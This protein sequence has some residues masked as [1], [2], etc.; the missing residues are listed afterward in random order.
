MASREA[1]VVLALAFVL[2]SGLASDYVTITR[3]ANKNYVPWAG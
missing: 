1:V 3:G 2:V